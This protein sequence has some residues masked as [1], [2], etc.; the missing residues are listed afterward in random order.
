VF[1]SGVPFEFNVNS[2][3]PSVPVFRGYAWLRHDDI[4]R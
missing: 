4:V 3:R 2:F 1:K